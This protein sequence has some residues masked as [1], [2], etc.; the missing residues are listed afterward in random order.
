[1]SKLTRPY[2]VTFIGLLVVC[3]KKA[4]SFGSDEFMNNNINKVIEEKTNDPFVLL[5]EHFF[6][7]VFLHN[8]NL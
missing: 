7:A 8:K 5:E 2:Y 6:N 1:M 3:P 4:L